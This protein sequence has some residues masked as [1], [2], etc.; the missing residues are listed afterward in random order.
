M[1]PGARQ[2]TLGLAL[3]SL[4]AGAMAAVSTPEPGDMALGSAKAPVTIVEYASVGCPHCA[5]WDITVFPAVK[6][7]LLDTGKAR[8]VLRE[9]I[10]GNATIAT[11]GFM[12][13]RC[14]GPAKY[15]A[16]VEAIFKRQDE[17]F[18][19]SGKAGQVLEEIASSAG[20]L[21]EAAFDACISDQ[22]GLDGLGAR[23]AQHT[24]VDK[25]ESTPTFFVG[26]RKLEGEQTFSQ[27][28]EAVRAAG[29][30]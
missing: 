22:K 1:R 12:L 9:M 16:V 17:M 21:D 6:A 26:E 8:L 14:A 23:V 5:A 2:I 20:G 13:A 24:N 25:V 4:G 19:S 28:A 7:K 10:N 15:F 29:R 11:G 27:L 30:R 18:E 3:A